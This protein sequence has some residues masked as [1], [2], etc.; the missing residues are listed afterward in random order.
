MKISLKQ[1]NEGFFSLQ[2]AA[3]APLPKEHHK[4]A[5][6]LSRI[7]KSANGE[8]ELMQESLRQLAISSGITPEDLKSGREIC[9]GYWEAERKFLREVEIEIWGDP[10]EPD[11]WELIC[12]RAELS[13]LDM[14]N[15]DWL[16][17][18]TEERPD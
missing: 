11:Q 4:T 7:Y 5:Y 2:K 1:L 14:A 16:F 3:R 6:K 12:E 10:F 15:L 13:P 17:K 8:V 9:A 18:L